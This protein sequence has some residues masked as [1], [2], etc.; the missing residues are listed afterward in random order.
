MS[1]MSSPAAAMTRSRVAIGVP[2]L[3]VPVA[4]FSLAFLVRMAATFVVTFPLSE[5]S[6]Y[7]VAVARNIATG[8]GLVVDAIWSYATPPLALPRA[9]FELWRPLASSLA[10]VPMWFLGPS[11][12]SA[13]VSF[14]LVGALLAPL[15]WFIARDAADRLNVPAQRRGYVAAAAGVLAAL[16]GP[17]VLAA[18]L[19]DSTLPFTV[20]IVSAAIVTPAAV[21]GQR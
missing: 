17:L 7:Y 15:T 18:A 3:A 2:A 13:Q 20:L 8:R 9:A 14:A 10:A 4:L 5:G 11:F 12:A 1:V 21:R 6:A 19:P 16:A